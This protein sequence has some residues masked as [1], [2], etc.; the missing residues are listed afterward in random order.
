LIRWLTLQTDP[1]ARSLA[2]NTGYYPT[3]PDAEFFAK[4]DIQ[5]LL[6]EGAGKR[7]S[8]FHFPGGVDQ[9]IGVW[10]ADEK[11]KQ[12]GFLGGPFHFL[13]Q[14]RRLSRDLKIEDQD[15]LSP[16]ILKCM[17]A[18]VQPWHPK[19]RKQFHS[20]LMTKFKVVKRSFCMRQQNRPLFIDDKA[21]ADFVRAM[22][23]K[24]KR[25]DLKILSGKCF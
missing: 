19:K 11:S 21:Y 2:E 23:K 25:R 16:P 24:S 15:I 4:T 9:T 8:R 1:Q 3:Q 10:P 22:K 20:D 18:M 13:P 14:L 5:P 17:S 7:Y 12:V 6:N